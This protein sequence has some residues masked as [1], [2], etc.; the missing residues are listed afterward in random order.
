MI[1][2]K[3]KLFYWNLLFN[4]FVLF[5]FLHRLNRIISDFSRGSEPNG[6]LSNFFIKE[7]FSTNQAPKQQSS[8]QTRT[9]YLSKV[10]IPVLRKSS[11][12]IRF[13][14]TFHSFSL[15]L[16]QTKPYGVANEI[17]HLLNRLLFVQYFFRYF[18][19]L[20]YVLV[21]KSQSNAIQLIKSKRN[22][23]SNPMIYLL[24]ALSLFC[25]ESKT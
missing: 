23:V 9:I 15:F 18:Y 10:R 25:M 19:L 3:N 24:A 1:G 7:M 2:V 6:T 17:L 14:S 21:R 4:E 16:R 11:A 12:H 13:R 5:Q 20:F 22:C 8:N